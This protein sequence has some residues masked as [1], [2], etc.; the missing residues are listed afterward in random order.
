MPRLN[1]RRKCRKCH[2]VLRGNDPALRV[3]PKCA[4]PDKWPFVKI[5]TI[6]P[7]ER[8]VLTPYAH[9]VL[10]DHEEFNQ[11]RRGTQCQRSYRRSRSAQE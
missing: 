11:P 7:D 6:E 8:I 9:Q 3:C 1:Y 10:R 4:I 2:D 5:P